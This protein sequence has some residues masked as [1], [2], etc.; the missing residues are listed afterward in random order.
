[1]LYVAYGSNLNIRQMMARCPDARIFGTSEIKDYR[2]KFKGSLTGSYLTIEKAK[3]YSVPVAIWDVSSSDIEALDR[4]EGYPN[5]YYKRTMVLPCSDGFRHRCFVYI[6]HEERP[7]G[8]PSGFYVD[9]CLEG[10][11]SFDFDEYKLYEALEYS[12]R[13]CRYNWN[14]RCG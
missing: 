5:F 9:T 8:V 1:M 4:Y 12:K 7:L 3:G 14:W 6:M 2:L 11:K 13:K 10:Y